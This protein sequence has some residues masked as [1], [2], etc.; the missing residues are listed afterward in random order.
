MY[1]NSVEFEIHFPNVGISNNRFL[2]LESLYLI[3]MCT[4]FE[5]Q[6]NK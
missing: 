3:E 5:K 6:C 2:Y 4:Y 1:L